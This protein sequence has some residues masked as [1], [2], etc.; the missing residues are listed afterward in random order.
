MKLQTLRTLLV[1]M[2]T[3][4][5]VSW[6]GGAAAQSCACANASLIGTAA[7]I[8]YSGGVASNNWNGTVTTGIEVPSSMFSPP[9]WQN[10]GRFNIDIQAS[11]VRI[12][13][14]RAATY[15]SGVYLNFL[16]NPNCP[17]AR[18]VGATFTTNRPDAVPHLTTF[19]SF[20]TTLNSVKLDFGNLGPPVTLP[21][22]D[23]QQGD[24]VQAQ[25]R[26]DCTAEP[27]TASTCCPPVT[28]ALVKGMFMHQG[29][30][31]S[32]YTQPLDTASA[33]TS[34]FV[35]GLQ[36]YLAYLQFVCPQVAGLK[37]DFFTGPV[38]PAVGTGP[39]GPLVGTDLSIP[40][41]SLLINS[42]TTVPALN[43]ALSGSG[44]MNLYIH[45]DSQYYRIS[46][47]ITGVNT[48]GNPVSCG[49]NAGECALDD[50]FGFVYS[51]SARMARGMNPVTD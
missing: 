3:V 47:K 24:W 31:A 42:G 19:S 49:F 17:G 46:V 2:S 44:G 48:Q 29:N 25:L 7:T 39:A 41:S 10:P 33:A 18:I 21:F 9:F 40:K 20:S 32:T 45:N 12:E 36:A 28:K 38:A 15:G 8:N 5:S 11:T 34:S 22:A 16:L 51:T 27:P 26:F 1:A 4:A 23:W 6:A 37:A 13:F 30:S 35:T 43:S 50:T 14:A